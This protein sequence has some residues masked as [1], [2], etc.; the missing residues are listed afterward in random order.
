MFDEMLERDHPNFWAVDLCREVRSTSQCGGENSWD[1]GMAIA[2]V[3]VRS[4][5]ANLV[6]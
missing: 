1:L 3:L 5:V 6:V 2:R 4:K